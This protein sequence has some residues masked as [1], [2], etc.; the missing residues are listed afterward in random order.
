MIHWRQ[1]RGGETEPRETAHFAFRRDGTGMPVR[2]VF[3]KNL[4]PDFRA[5]RMFK[6]KITAV[7]DIAKRSL[8]GNWQAR[9]RH[10]DWGLLLLSV[11]RTWVFRFKE[12]PFHVT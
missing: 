10:L 11:I 3:V 6:A 8:S 1:F 4:W 5:P 7:G 12:W 2:H 9:F